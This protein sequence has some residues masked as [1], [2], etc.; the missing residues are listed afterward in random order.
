MTKNASKFDDPAE[1]KKAINQRFGNDNVLN[2]AVKNKR[3]PLFSDDFSM[4]ILGAY[5]G[6]SSKLTTSLLDNVYSTVI[7]NFNT[8]VCAAITPLF[9]LA[10][11]PSSA[12]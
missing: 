3:P 2:L 8:K 11:A 12:T 4:K 9:K 1:F 10:F 7:Y 5:S 6:D